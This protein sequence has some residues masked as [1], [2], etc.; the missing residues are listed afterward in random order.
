MLL[1]PLPPGVCKCEAAFMVVW[2]FGVA[3]ERVG[4]GDESS[5]REDD[6]FLFVRAFFFH[7]HHL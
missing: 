2:V 6:H 3:E 5:E 1:A 7:S 4:E